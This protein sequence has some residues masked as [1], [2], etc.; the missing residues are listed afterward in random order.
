MSSESTSPVSLSSSS[1]LSVTSSTPWTTVFPSSLS[2][3]VTPVLFVS[4]PFVTCRDFSWPV[5]D[6]SEIP[7]STFWTS[8]LSWSTSP[9][10]R[11]PF[12][13]VYLYTTL[14]VD[15]PTGRSLKCFGRWFPRTVSS[16]SSTSHRGFSRMKTQESFLVF[17]F[18]SL[19]VE[20]SDL[21][22]N[23][24]TISSTRKQ[25]DEVG[26]CL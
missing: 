17:T 25:I 4:T 26:S 7:L 24:S 1:V 15:L 14:P 5:G 22:T 6:F 18:V 19:S 11:C 23:G 12:W 2:F 21:S 8:L 10:T 16:L 9:V 13:K 20:E 3:S